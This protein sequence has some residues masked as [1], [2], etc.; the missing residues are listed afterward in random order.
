[1]KNGSAA[2]DEERG[3]ADIDWQ[4]LMA[5]CWELRRQIILFSVGFAVLIFVFAFWMGR[6]YSSEGFM[7]APRKFAEYNAERAAFWDR[8]TLRHY[9]DENKKLDDVNGQYLLAKLSEP[10]VQQHLQAVLPLSKDD[11]RFM[12]DAKG[13]LDA[14]GI[15]GFSIT[16][17]DQSA[18]NAQARVQLLGDYIKDTMLSEDLQDTI[19]TKAGEAKEKKQQIDN[20][21]IQ[22]KL[23]LTQASSRLEAARAIAG[24]YP[25]A[26]KMEARQL[27]STASDSNASRYLSPMAQLVG[28]E[29]E[30]ADLKSQ[31]VLLERDAEQNALRSAFFE[32]MDESS[33]RTKTGHALLA[34]F[35]KAGQAVFAGKDLQDDKIR[36]VYNQITLIAEKMRTKHITEAR[37]VS[38]PTLPDRRSGPGSLALVLLSLIGG[39]ML[40]S[41]IVLLGDQL[42]AAKGGRGIVAHDEEAGPDESVR[43][44]RAA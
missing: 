11:L 18:Q 1:M 30:I 37:F 40:G 23:A 8:E 39:V 2:M 28:I 33:R 16:F 43:P 35:V 14:V 38:G 22:K 29:S 25:E 9:L 13:V 26:S 6:Q 41:A 7:R 31:L 17:K 27:L 42:S 32:R 12:T 34:E 15:L 10:F 24:K 21:I 3:H 20:L 19:Y 5:R 44:I 36:E 4:A